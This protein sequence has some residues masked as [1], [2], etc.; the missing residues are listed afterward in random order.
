M[1]LVYQADI[2]KHC[3]ILYE[4]QPIR[5]GNANRIWRYTVSK[6]G[7][8]NLVL[9]LGFSVRVDQQA[10][11][12]ELIRNKWSAVIK[13]MANQTCELY[14]YHRKLGYSNPEINR[15]EQVFLKRGTQLEFII[16]FELDSQDSESQKEPIETPKFIAGFRPY[17]DWNCQTENQIRIYKI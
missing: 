8:Y 7:M 5:I 9:M 1:P 17:T 2:N 12:D 11:N 4:N 14:A 3:E 6:D 16:D 13:I 15:I 10:I